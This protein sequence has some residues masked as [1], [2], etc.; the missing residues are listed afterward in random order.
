ME[1]V[2]KM[3]NHFAGTAY[4]THR[5]LEELDLNKEERKKTIKEITLRFSDRQYEMLKSFD[6]LEL[7]EKLNIMCGVIDFIVKQVKNGTDG[8][9]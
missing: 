6:T 7:K 5:L 3:Q 9:R 2:K 4:D 8:Q 1:E